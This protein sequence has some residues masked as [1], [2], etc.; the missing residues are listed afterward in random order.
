M[1]GR[2]RDGVGVGQCRICGKNE[3]NDF[4]EF[5]ALQVCSLCEP[6]SRASPCDDPARRGLGRCTHD[7]FFPLGSSLALVRKVEKNK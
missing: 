2:G 5:L 1:W 7:F 3:F 6:R 4:L